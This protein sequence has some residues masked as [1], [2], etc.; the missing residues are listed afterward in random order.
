[1]LLHVVS[2]FLHDILLYFCLFIHIS[3]TINNIYDVI[4]IYKGNSM[5]TYR[6]PQ[7]FSV[8]LTLA[9]YNTQL[10]PV[11]YGVISFCFGFQNQESI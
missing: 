4:S 8:L 2:P 3:C 1:V 10:F 5:I 11:C 7:F 6:D 9:P